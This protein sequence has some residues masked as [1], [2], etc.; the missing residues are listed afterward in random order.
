MRE[1]VYWPKQDR[2]IYLDEKATP[3][4]WDEHW[5]DIGAPPPVNPK[6]EV[7]TVT[8]KYIGPSSRVLEGGCG[9]ADKVKAMV[10]G[11][12]D[13]V[14][15]DYAEVTVDQARRTYPDIDV[16]KGDVRALDFP[17]NS[18]DG[19]WSIGVIEHFW[20]GYDAILSEAARVLRPNGYLFL[21][22]PW[23]SPYRKSKARS[24]AYEVV[25]PASE[26]ASF[27]QFALGRREVSA[28]LAKHGFRLRSWHG[29]VSEISMQADMIAYERQVEWLLGSRG[30]IFKRVLRRVI[31]RGLD[32]Y[33]GHSFLAVAQRS[34]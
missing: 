21:S 24:G 18:F 32:W 14:G 9:R 17:D 7:I 3:Q 8:R 27:Y 12:F 19:Y 29:W 22:A 23:F 15:V 13:A 2:L 1:I 31:T 16:R 25:D 4:F 11:G 10:H 33:C 20:D 28:Q 34:S 5:Q 6:D 30:S 26:P